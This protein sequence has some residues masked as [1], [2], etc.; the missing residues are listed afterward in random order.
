MSILTYE[1][2]QT[3]QQLE[4]QAKFADR[5]E[6]QRANLIDHWERRG[7]PLGLDL[8]EY[9]ELTDAL[10]TYPAEPLGCGEDY[11]VFGYV[12]QCGQKVKITKT[13][14]T[15]II[16][17]AYFTVGSSEWASTC[18]PCTEQEFN[19]QVNPYQNMTKDL[20]TRYYCDL[21]GDTK[22]L[23]YFDPKNLPPNRQLSEDKILLYKSLLERKIKLRS[24][25]PKEGK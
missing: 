10:S 23:V 9:Q 11:D 15:G 7:K 24:F 16:L 6:K 2:W 8:E 14:K 4:E 12:A 3:L 17:V 25:I 22:G 19:K 5:T 1:D 18:Y 13:S 20:D 21:D